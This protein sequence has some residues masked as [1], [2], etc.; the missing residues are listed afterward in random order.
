MTSPVYIARSHGFEVCVQPQF[1][2]DQSDP[3]EDHFVWA[4]HVCIINKSEAPAQLR[5]RHWVI[6]DAAGFVQE[7]RGAGVVGEEP[8][9][10]PGGRY[11]YTSGV[12]LTTPSGLMHGSYEMEA[13]DGS[14]FDI[15]IPPF[16][17]DSQ[18]A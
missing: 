4:Y 17:L 5:N 13:P 12:P 6:T 11:D 2:D 15:R 14:R 8:E 9:I 1:L 10:E 18:F 16:A 7:V 3:D